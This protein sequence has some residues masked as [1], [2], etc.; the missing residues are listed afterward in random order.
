M[1]QVSCHGMLGLRAVLTVQQ[2]AEI[3]SITSALM[4][5]MIRSVPPDQVN[6]SLL[7]QLKNG[8]N[9]TVLMEG[10][11]LQIMGIRSKPITND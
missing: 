8:N 6:W 9:T 5:I 11:T 4:L 3:L 2:R 10:K 7:R 1:T